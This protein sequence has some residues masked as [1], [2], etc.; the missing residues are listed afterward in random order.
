MESREKKTR[1]YQEQD[2][3][4][5]VQD[6]ASALVAVLETLFGLSDEEE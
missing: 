2:P 1:R 3:E 4:K 5:G 6:A